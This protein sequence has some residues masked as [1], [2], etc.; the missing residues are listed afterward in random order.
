[1]AKDLS[2]ATVKL[3]RAVMQSRAASL[4]TIAALSAPLV[5][6][7]VGLAF[8][9]NRG[10]EERLYNQQSADMAALGAALT[11]QSDATLSDTQLDAIASDIVRANGQAGGTVNATLLTDFPATG[12]LSLKVDVESPVSWVLAQVLGFEGTYDVASTATAIINKYDSVAVPSPC[13]FAL[14]NNNSAIQ[15]SGG[16]QINAAGCTVA[17]VG[18][19]NNGGTSITADKIIAAGGDITNNYGTLTANELRYTGDLAFQSWNTSGNA[20]TATRS[21]VATDLPDPLADNTRLAAAF[22]A[23]GSLDSYSAAS[24]PTG[25]NWT[26]DG[27]TYPS[28]VTYTSTGGRSGYHTVNGNRHVIGHLTIDGGEDVRFANGADI[29]ISGNLSI[30]GGTTVDFGNRNVYVQG[31]TTIGGG[32]VVGGGTGNRQFGRLVIGG[33]GKSKFGAGNFVVTNGLKI[34]GDSELSLGDGDYYF[35]RSSGDGLAINL[36]G[37]ARL[38]MGDG[39]FSA[40]GNVYTQGGSK[41]VFGKTT[42]HKINGNM[43]IAGAAL[44]G[45]GRYSVNGNFVNGTGGTVWPY[46]STLTGTQYGPMLEGVS[47]AGYD[48]AGV[49][50]TFVLAGALNLNGGAKTKLV[51]APTDQLGGYMADLMFASKTTN[52]TY[53]GAGSQN[54][55][56]GA[57]YIPNSH[58]RMSGGNTTGASTGCLML[59][60]SRITVSG[61]GQSFSS[62]DAITSGSSGT[63]AARIRL[64]R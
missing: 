35:N 39:L 47:V 55:F 58:V 36:L 42:D 21:N 32:T 41:I 57:M 49:N 24:F 60:A 14:S 33:G 1:M 23:L 56:Q 48:M 22:A 54:D 46:T 4:G 34:D 9:L 29:T 27:S 20:P 13:F 25:T 50:V 53:W 3:C 19:V 11:Y 37:S 15:T 59:I 52:D 28:A 7:G 61:G 51:A 62:C 64:I 12:D 18:G 6:G 26:I 40:N 63:T 31:Q 43:T 44:F 16:G 38:F 45:A 8:D 10:Y 2:S 30:G 17:S 5:I